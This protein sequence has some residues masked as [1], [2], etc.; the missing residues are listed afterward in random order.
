MPMGDRI[1]RG[2]RTQKS[3]VWFEEWYITTYC[4]ANRES[5][6]IRKLTYGTHIRYTDIINMQTDNSDMTTRQ[7]SQDT[8]GS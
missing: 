3:G 7:N 8:V 6:Q 1:C 4:E 5:R 2:V